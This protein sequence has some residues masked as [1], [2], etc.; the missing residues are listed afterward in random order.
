MLQLSPEA[1]SALTG[2]SLG[3]KDANYYHEVDGSSTGED[4]SL[5]GLAGEN[6]HE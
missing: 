6:E 1:A 4:E 5:A 2:R 3:D